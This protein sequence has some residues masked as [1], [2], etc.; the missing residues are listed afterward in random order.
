MVSA[1]FCYFEKY[2]LVFVEGN[3]DSSKSCSMLADSI[4][5]FI[6]VFHQRGCLLQKDNAPCH[7][8]S[9]TKDWFFDIDVEFIE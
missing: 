7:A 6:K 1:C 5:P 8:F 9:Q 4:L 2:E 3:L